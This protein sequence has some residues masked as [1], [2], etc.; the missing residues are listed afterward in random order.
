MTSKGRSLPHCCTL[1]WIVVFKDECIP[2]LF[3][4]DVPC[5]HSGS[6]LSL[7][8]EYLIICSLNEKIMGKCYFNIT[9]LLN[10]YDRVFFFFTATQAVRN[11]NNRCTHNGNVY[12]LTATPLGPEIPLSPGMPIS[13]WRRRRD[14][15]RRG[16]KCLCCDSKL[17]IFHIV[18]RLSPSNNLPKKAY[19][20]HT[21]IPGSPEGPGSPG[22]PGSPWC[23]RKRNFKGDLHY[24]NFALKVMVSNSQLLLW[25][26]LHQPFL[27]GPKNKKTYIYI[28][29]TYIMCITSEALKNWYL[30][31]TQEMFDSVSK[32][33]Q[34]DRLV[35]SLRQYHGG[36]RHPMDTD[37]VVTPALLRPPSA[38][39]I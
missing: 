29:Y 14:M 13:P 20:I 1:K 10:K 27:E 6:Y 38:L 19:Q 24:I 39:L 33:S 7:T 3:H 4:V 22:F 15:V 18:K 31:F 34:E 25:I 16:Q 37:K 9:L 17:F 30:T 32:H 12:R 21:G 23:K 36:Q 5:I 2:F 11:I 28:I 26:P 35:L 8:A